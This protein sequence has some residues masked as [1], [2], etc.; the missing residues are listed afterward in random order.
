MERTV[1][2]LEEKKITDIAKQIKELNVKQVSELVVMIKKICGV[3]EEAEVMRSSDGS[4]DS[5]VKDETKSVGNVSIKLIELPESAEKKFKVYY[6]LQDIYK[7]IKGEKI[8][9]VSA[10]NIALKEDGIILED[11]PRNKVEGEGG[12]KEKFENLKT[13]IEIKEVNN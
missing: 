6:L 9:L 1:E 4:S 3:E 2:S 5:Q 12:I 10:K 11:I 13:K 8:G 7:E